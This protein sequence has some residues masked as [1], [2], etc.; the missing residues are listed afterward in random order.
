MLFSYNNEMFC[1]QNEIQSEEDG[2][3]RIEDGQ[4]EGTEM[5]DLYG[6]ENSERNSLLAL[7]GSFIGCAM[8]SMSTLATDWADLDNGILWKLNEFVSVNL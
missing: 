5:S 1:Q 8:N 3:E 2:P 4:K 6:Y 7:H